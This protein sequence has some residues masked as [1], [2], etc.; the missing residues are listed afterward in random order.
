MSQSQKGMLDMQI[1]A[2]QNRTNGE[3]TKRA[4]DVYKEIS[5]IDYNQILSDTK[6]KYEEKAKETKQPID[7]TVVTN[8]TNQEFYGKLN[9]YLKKESLIIRQYEK[10][11]TKEIVYVVSK[12]VK[13]YSFVVDTKLH[14]S[15]SEVK[16]V[17]EVKETKKSKRVKK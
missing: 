4:Y 8:D 3:L 6:E 9:D 17:K 7:M 11:E 5:W 16:E 13:E 2:Y 1:Q 10:P 15:T 12:K 14:I